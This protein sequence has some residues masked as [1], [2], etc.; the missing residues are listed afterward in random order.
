MTIW[1][2]EEEPD[3]PKVWICDPN[4]GEPVLVTANM[5]EP[6]NRGSRRWLVHGPGGYW[7]TWP[8]L[9]MRGPVT[10]NDPTPQPP[11]VMW[12]P[13]E[14]RLYVNVSDAKLT[15]HRQTIRIPEDAQQMTVR[16][17]K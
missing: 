8:E 12:S 15:I 17:P 13:S 14:N 5:A 9:L 1:E 6:L 10:D 7:H 4:T 11:Y 2:L 16:E 3:V